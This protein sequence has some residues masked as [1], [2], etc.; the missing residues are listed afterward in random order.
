MFTSYLVLRCSL[1]FFGDVKIIIWL[2]HNDVI[3]IRI[4]NPDVP[5]SS[6]PY[7]KRDSIRVK[8]K[9]PL[10]SSG[11]LDPRR[12]EYR[13]SRGLRRAET[14]RWG[15]LVDSHLPSVNVRVKDTSVGTVLSKDTLGCTSREA[16]NIDNE[17]YLNNK[18]ESHTI[19]WNAIS[20]NCY[21][22]L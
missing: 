7:I 3:R 15:R 20:P 18:F 12:N 9:T 11:C 14:V 19:F 5:Y 17:K 21:N 6:K 8:I 10:E 1:N 16:S 2:R 4:K 22:L 13:H